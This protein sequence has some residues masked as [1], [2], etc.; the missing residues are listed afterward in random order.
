MRELLGASGTPA[1]NPPVSWF[2]QVK[3]P[4]QQLEDVAQLFL[5]TR[6]QCAQCHHHPFEKW[7]QH[8]YYRFSAFFSRVGRKG[9]ALVHHR[10]GAATAVNK[11]TKQE[12][13]PAAL[14]T[15]ELQIPQEEDPRLV[16]AD[17]MRAPGNPFFAKA[18]ANR[19]WKHFL[20]RGL[21]EPEDDMR[22]TN[23]P[24]N[25]ELLDVLAQILTQSGFD[26]RALIREITRSETY[27]RSALPNAHNASDR[28]NFSRYFPKRLPAEVL[29]DSIGKVCK[30]P[31][32]FPGMP[33]GT[34]AI[35]LPDNSFNT[36]SYFLTVFGRPESSSACECE[37][38]QDASLAQALHLI[39][40]KDLQ[41]RIASDLGAA[42]LYA[43][44]GEQDQASLDEL[45]LT[46][47]A[48]KPTDA[49]RNLAL[50]HLNK[51]RTAADGQPLDPAKSRRQGF[52]DLLWTLLN[53][54]EFLFNH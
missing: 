8:D 46:A 20:N 48:R 45:Y 52:E 35:G 33:A 16:L 7:S 23:P 28:Q 50:Q 37:R 2:I 49:E 13:K 34:R 17:W 22:D 3:E 12:V 51:A 24:S 30:V 10:R 54:K 38:S 14:G 21:V 4:Q 9:P 43:A 26:Q 42:A 5:G 41:D 19:Y 18:L 39:N 53:T 25:P 44:K 11:K 31:G 15:D 29:F 6:L 27:Q 32:T 36:T 1:D 40:A 47:L